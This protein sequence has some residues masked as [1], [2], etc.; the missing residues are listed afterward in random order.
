MYPAFLRPVRALSL[1]LNEEVAGIGPSD[2]PSR[3]GRGAIGAIRGLLLYLARYYEDIVRALVCSCRCCDVI[4]ERQDY[5]LTFLESGTIIDMH[6]RL[7]TLLAATIILLMVL[8]PVFN[9]F[10]KWDK[11]PELP[12]AG[13][14]TE[15]TLMIMALEVGMGVAVAWGS[16]VFLGWLSAMLLPQL[17]ETGSANASRGVRATEYLLLLFSPPWRPLSLRI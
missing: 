2:I 13:H 1:S 17:F 9:A 15:T 4:V 6:R 16:V 10:D 8:P 5:R 7:L 3:S 14:D 12:M 11:T